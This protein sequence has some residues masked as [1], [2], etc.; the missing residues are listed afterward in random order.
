MRTLPTLLLGDVKNIVRDPMLVLYIAVPFMMATAFRFGLPFMQT[1]VAEHLAFD[2]TPYYSFAMAFVVM[3][4]PMMVGALVGFMLLDERDENILSYIAVTPLSKT[5]YVAY[6]TTMPVLLSVLLAYV[7]HALAGLSYISPVK[8]LP[9]ALMAALEA[10]VL[11]LFLAA[12]AENKV[13]GLAYAKGMGVFYV[14][15][16]IGEFA[17]LPW[18]YIG[19]V[20]PPYWITKAYTSATAAHALPFFESYAFYVIVGLALHILVITFF[21][22]VFNRKAN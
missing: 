18:H 3:V 1:L 2:I 12:F 10:P 15:P 11:A 6:R 4:T 21:I 5:G 9:V 7:A 22:R 20:F 13:E 8:L 19:G 17:P 14:G 16:F